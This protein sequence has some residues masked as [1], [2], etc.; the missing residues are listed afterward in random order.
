MRSEP[1]HEVPLSKLSG[2]TPR[3]CYDD[4]SR[5]GV[6]DVADERWHEPPRN[7]CDNGGTRRRDCRENNLSAVMRS[8]R[9]ETWPPTT[10]AEKKNIS[11]EEES[12]TG[13][14]AT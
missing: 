7:V 12:V 2:P 9:V 10:V 11:N 3:G 8:A 6:L 1:R 5:V 14:V 4:L 13:Q